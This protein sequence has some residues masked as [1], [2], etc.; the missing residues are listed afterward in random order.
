MCIGIRTYI[1]RHPY[2]KYTDMITL[3]YDESP[4]LYSYRIKTIEIQADHASLKTLENIMDNA[5]HEK[6]GLV[7]SC[8]R[9][10][11]NGH[12]IIA[13]DACPRIKDHSNV[14]LGYEQI[15]ALKILMDSGAGMDCYDACKEA[16]CSLEEL[17]DLEKRKLIDIKKGRL[18]PRLLYP[19]ITEL[20]VEVIEYMEAYTDLI[21]MPP[22]CDN[23]HD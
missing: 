23:E 17:I 6:Y 15:I 20:G 9:L 2:H 14:N 10:S 16:D 7:K 3:P 1:N 11:K 18:N 8:K 12:E 19:V 21:P 13:I 22:Y 5:A 4:A